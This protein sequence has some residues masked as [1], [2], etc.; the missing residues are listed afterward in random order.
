[1][2]IGGVRVR[3]AIGTIIAQLMVQILL[4]NK[5]QGVRKVKA[6]QY[7]PRGFINFLMRGLI[8]MGC[9]AVF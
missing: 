2:G 1:M 9:D 4:A 5:Q 7:I 3:P 8:P 6:S